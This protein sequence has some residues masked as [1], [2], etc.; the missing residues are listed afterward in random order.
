[1]RIHAQTHSH[2]NTYIEKTTTTREQTKLKNGHVNTNQTHTKQSCNHNQTI[3]II[4]AAGH[5]QTKRTN[6]NT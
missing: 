5:V 4:R 6:S 1:V 2:T 3:I